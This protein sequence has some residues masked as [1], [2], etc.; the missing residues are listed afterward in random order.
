MDDK[1]NREQ[2]LGT[3]TRQLPVK[4]SP[5]ERQGFADRLAQ[6]EP[7]QTGL[8]VDKARMIERHKRERK[9]LDAKIEELDAERG[10]VAAGYREGVVLRPIEVEIIADYVTGTKCPRR[11]DTGEY[12]T[13][14]RKLLD[15]SERQMHMVP[16]KDKPNVVKMHAVPDADDSPSP[17]LDDDGLGDDD[18]LDDDGDDDF[19]NFDD[20]AGAAMDAEEV[21]DAK[22][23][24]MAPPLFIVGDSVE[25]RSGPD[26]AVRYGKVSAVIVATDPDDEHLYDVPTTNGFVRL[27]QSEMWSAN[28]ETTTTEY[29]VPAV[30]FGGAMKVDDRRAYIR[31]CTDT[32]ELR[33]LL[34]I[35]E[36]KKIQG[37]VVKAIKDRLAALN[38]TPAE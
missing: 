17:T 19:D 1:I 16:Q 18:W 8:K 28:P 22:Q 33:H 14:E 9:E 38:T 11:K 12:L 25:Y 4:L 21:E 2:V 23:Q 36:D 24:T 26:L 10:R 3:D 20:A 35:A 34:D 32:D 30:M 31:A 5:D 27:P 37:S 6:I 13:S 29:K 15:D 7:E